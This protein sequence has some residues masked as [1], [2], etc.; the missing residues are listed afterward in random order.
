M[1]LPKDEHNNEG[2]GRN[3]EQPKKKGL[4]AIKKESSSKSP[5]V[6]PPVIPAEDKKEK[7]KKKL[8]PAIVIPGVSVLVVGGLVGG[9]FLFNADTKEE[10]EQQE[11]GDS[12]IAKYKDVPDSES[13]SSSS[14]VDLPEY[15][16]TNW[17]D[18]V[19]EDLNAWQAH[20]D[21]QSSD[22]VVI[23]EGFLGDGSGLEDT[24]NEDWDG[25]GHSVAWDSELHRPVSEWDKN[26]ESAPP[27]GLLRQHIED[28]M[29]KEFPA[30][31]NAASQYPSRA[32]GYVNNP[33]QVYLPD[34]S[35]N[36]M[37]SFVLS[38][39]IEFFFGHSVQ[40]L[41]NP[42]YGDW[43]DLTLGLDN[44]NSTI[45]QRKFGD[46]FS[47]DYFAENIKDNNIS[48]LPILA[49]WDNQSYEDFGREWYGEMED[50]KIVFQDG[51]E[52][53]DA[54]IDVKYSRFASNGSVD[55]K[56]GILTLTASPNYESPEDTNNRYV[57]TNAKLSMK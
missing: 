21:G 20:V 50:V 48:A 4:A 25:T 46:M 38:E 26:P 7:K 13:Q 11:F 53:F 6:V 29:R 49:N 56:K 15:A 9:L 31:R 35:Y 44:K 40:R 27:G 37:Y 51:T 45:A 33:D 32:E 57:I 43:V 34:G 5:I 39:D 12:E 8:S 14:P 1:A 19:G 36:P 52:V 42:L 3:D 24:P 2:E 10:V 22:D 54:T 16:F 47:S 41:L 18:S 28:L 17:E 30:I 23:P 55:E